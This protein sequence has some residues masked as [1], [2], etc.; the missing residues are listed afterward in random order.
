MDFIFYL[1]FT[2]LGYKNSPLFWW[3]RLGNYQ[4]WF[5]NL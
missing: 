3:T 4:G 1:D 2:C 5:R